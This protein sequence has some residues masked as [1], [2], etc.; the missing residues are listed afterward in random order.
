MAIELE[1]HSILTPET[2]YNTIENPALTNSAEILS[3][4]E[5]GSIYA[6]RLVS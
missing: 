1:T 6:S 5:R 4:N 3:G 2:G